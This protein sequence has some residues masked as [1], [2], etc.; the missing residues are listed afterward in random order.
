MW[1]YSKNFFWCKRYS[2]NIIMKLWFAHCTL[3]LSLCHDRVDFPKFHGYFRPLNS[4]L[5]WNEITSR[6][7]YDTGSLLA[8]WNFSHAILK[9]ATIS[10]WRSSLLC[11]CCNLANPIRL[12]NFDWKVGYQHIFLAL[13]KLFQLVKE[14]GEIGKEREREK[15]WFSMTKTSLNILNK[16]FFAKWSFHVV[17]LIYFSSMIESPN[18]FLKA[19]RNL[20]CSTLPHLCQ[21]M[22]K[23]TLW[24]K[25]FNSR[26]C[27]KLQLLLQVHSFG[28]CWRNTSF[29]GNKKYCRVANKLF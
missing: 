18:H 2:V 20:I 1:F 23:M 21:E 13:I 24:C 16:V 11:P 8:R 28:F 25:S 17:L 19:P 9:R 27:K 3:H 10:I 5:L 7:H 4:M 29:D 26:T 15:E 6:L 12:Y 22:M 14:K